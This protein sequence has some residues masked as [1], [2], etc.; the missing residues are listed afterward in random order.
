MNFILK[1][2]FK[3]NADLN[4]K[5]DFRGSYEPALR[6]RLDHVHVA[7]AWSTVTLQQSL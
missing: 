5:N 7:S 1:C 6:L 2:L 3:R 4:L